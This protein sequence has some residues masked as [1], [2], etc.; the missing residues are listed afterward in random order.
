MSCPSTS[1]QCDSVSVQTAVSVAMEGAETAGS[2]LRFK[3]IIYYSMACPGV[4]T[5]SDCLFLLTAV[6]SLS[7]MD[8]T[9][10]DS[11]TKAS[12]LID[13]QSLQCRKLQVLY[14]TAVDRLTTC[15]RR[16]QRQIDSLIYSELSAVCRNHKTVSAETESL[17][18]VVY[19][20]SAEN[21]TGRNSLNCCFRRRNRNRNRISVGLYTGPLKL[22]L[23]M[24]PNYRLGQD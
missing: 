8:G 4:R 5:R 11:E 14:Q 1:R 17:P 15:Y 23:T 16:L 9:S 19:E 3:V 10:V 24:N 21:E 13:I 12:K 6:L 7:C 18:N 2:R 20:N 22:T